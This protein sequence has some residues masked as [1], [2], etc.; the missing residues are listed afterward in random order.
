MA[1]I[2]HPLHSQSGQSEEEHAVRACDGEVLEEVVRSCCW[3][4][5]SAEGNGI[6]AVGF[7]C[8]AAGENHILLAWA[9]LKERRGQTISV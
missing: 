3:E 9:S 7:D 6:A 4:H 5:D 1:F 2:C 8:N